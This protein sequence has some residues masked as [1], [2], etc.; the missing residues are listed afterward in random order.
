MILA[1][2]SELLN[3]AR[4]GDKA[5]LERL[6]AEQRECL[7]R[8]VQVRL[9]A[10]I[11]ARLD[12]S[13]ILQE[14]YLEVAN[15]VNDI[16][17][18]EKMPFAVWMRLIVSEKI[19]DAH[20]QHL[21]VQARDPRREISLGGHSFETATSQCIAA[22]LVGSEI[23]PSGAAMHAET[24]ERVQQALDR[25]DAL[26]REVICLRNIEQLNRQET[27][28]VLN[29]SEPAAAKRYLRALKK[30]RELLG[31]SFSELRGI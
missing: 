30:L 25:M 20:R 24:I 11:Q 31:S 21:G 13:D 14:A 26:D 8:M 29:L 5:A 12:P 15:R 22:Y 6:L 23:S 3:L 16:P 18:T 10:R 28:A 1:P 7:R 9:D 4:S 19:V 17:S 2:A 27:A